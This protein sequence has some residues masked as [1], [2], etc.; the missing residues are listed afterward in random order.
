MIL[1]YLACF[2]LFALFGLLTAAQDTRQVSE[3]KVPPACTTVDAVL[4]A[5]NGVLS[6]ADEHRTDTA[7]IQGAIDSC[8]PGHGVVLRAHGERSVFLSGPLTLKSGVTLVIEA[9]TVLAAS[10]DPRLF[11]LAPGT[12]GIVSAKGHGCR[13]LISV[14]GATG[15]GIMGDGAIDGRGGATVL[16][17]KVT[18]WD[19]AH[20]AKVT[21]QSQS[22]PWMIVVR[23]S[24]DFTLYRITLRN[25]PGFHVGVNQTDGFTAWGVKI[26]TP[27]TARNTDGIDPGSS[28]NVTITNCW[29][30]TGDDDVAVKSG[31]AGPS[32][33]ISVLHNHFFTGHGMSIGSGTDGGVDHMLVDDLTIDGADNGIRI[34]SDRSR[35]GLVEN[36]EY[37]DVCIRNTRNPIVLTPMYTTFPGNLLPVYRKILLKDVHIVSPGA[38]TFLGLDAEHKLEVSLDNVF[39]DGIGQSQIIAGNAA[40]GIGPGQGNLSPS[41]N[42]VSITKSPEARPGTPLACDARFAAFP[43]LPTA[44]EM[45][46]TVP[47]EDQTLYVAADGTGD[48]YSIQRALDVAPATGGLVLVAPGTYREVLTISKPHITLRSANPDAGKAI[49]VNDR[50]AGTAGGTLHSATVNVTGDDFTAENITFQNDYNATHPQLPQGSQAL[51]LL[52]RGDRAVFRN[53]RLLGNQD[54]LFTGSKQCTGEGQERSCTLARQYFSHCFIEGNVDFIFGDGK[55][56]FDN[57]EIRSNAHSEG[58]ITAQGKSYASEDSGYV[59]HRCRLTADPEVTNVFLGRPWRPYATVVYLDTEM[60]AHVQPAGWREWHPGETH[61][62]DTAFYAEQGSTG[63]GAKLS[64]RDSHVHVLT[65]DEAVKYLPTNFLRGADG[66]NPAESGR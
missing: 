9:N 65:A 54:T 30:S 38:Y 10:R 4:A 53:V 12:C 6:D 28:R 55:T 48:F 29:I 44:P 57:C 19:L 2:L 49:V 21:D 50:S 22:V 63:P 51:A 24:T 36:I 60:G 45:A 5:K 8:A 41:G 46:G 37:R 40:I 61:S 26:M 58:F 66:W 33:N 47:P 59:F 25:S 18:W 42:D 14:T 1:R 16:G 20:E 3:P 62:L 35:G 31:K 17:Q 13:P 23:N 27:K 64:E 52:V 34:K 43:E 7:R 32:S 56:A 11:D 15:S 39:A